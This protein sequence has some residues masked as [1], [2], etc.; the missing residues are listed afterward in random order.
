MKK[1]QLWLSLSIMVLLHGCFDNSDNA[2]K[3]NTDGTQSSVK[4]QQ[5]K[6]LTNKSK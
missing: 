4:M 1:L 6:S 3:S 5:G 2:T